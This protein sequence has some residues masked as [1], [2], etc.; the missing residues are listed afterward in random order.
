MTMTQRMATW[1]CACALAAAIGAGVL[2]AQGQTSAP[3]GPQEGIKVHGRWT[4]EILNPDGTLVVR[5]EFQNA[6]DS[7]GGAFLSR[8][9]TRQRAM[10]EWQ[11][12]L[13][14]VGLT[15]RP[16]PSASNGACNIGEVA[17]SDPQ[18]Q[19]KTLVVSVPVSG[20]NAGRIVLAGHA[21]A[22]ADGDIVRVFTS[23][24]DCPA[25]TAPASC[26]N[27]RASGFTSR[28]MNPILQ[29]AAGQIVQVTIVISFS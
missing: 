20:P 24:G 12:G 1:G 7:F 22:E 17:S 4:I 3:G 13:W 28:D 18:A 6:L 29:V 14:Q 21:T 11:V 10:G 15:R 27:V 8:L 26:A 9:L 2:Q 19:F 25:A 5:R 16:C 23:V